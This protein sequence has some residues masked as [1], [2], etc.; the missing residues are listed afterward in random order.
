MKRSGLTARTAPVKTPIPFP[1]AAAQLLVLGACLLALGACEKD[2]CTDRWTQEVWAPVTLDRE[3]VHDSIALL[4]A[5]ELC[6]GSGLYAYGDYLFANLPREGYHLLDNRDPAN[7]TPVAFLRVPGATHMAFV[8]GRLVSDSY[9]DLLVLDFDGQRLELLSHH[10]N[11]LLHDNQLGPDDPGETV[12]GY[13]LREME[14][15]QSCDGGLTGRWGGCAFCDVRTLEATSFDVGRGGGLGSPSVNTSG[16]LSRIAFAGQHVYV[17]GETQ[18]ATYR[19]DG[20]ELVNTNNQQPG[21]GLET[22]TVRAG[23]LYLGSMTGMHIYDLADP[24]VPRF[25]SRYQHFT[26]CDP[27]AVEGDRAVVTLRSGTR[28][29]GAAEN[30]AI[31]L[32]ISDRDNPRELQTLAMNNPRGVALHQGSLYVC[33]GP[34]GLRVYDF[35]DGAIGLRAREGQGDDSRETTDVAVLPYPTG[36]VVLTIGPDHLTQYRREGVAEVSRLSRLQADRCAGL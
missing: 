36:T 9:A 3:T 15:E 16:S 32:D 30:V 4:P 6:V 13:E 2:S 23:F 12:I 29:G 28:C 14:F 21:W 11:F 31:V 1:R 8:D 19:L 22:A 25:R 27:V 26:A 17:L 33:D 5:R 20:G 35:D 34:N 18:L 7:P 10:P 24:A